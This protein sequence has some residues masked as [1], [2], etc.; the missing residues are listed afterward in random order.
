MN[1]KSKCPVRVINKIS[2]QI[3]NLR[4]AIFLFRIAMV[5]LRYSVIKQLCFSVSVKKKITTWI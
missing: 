5:K 1:L 2:S 3:E 4:K